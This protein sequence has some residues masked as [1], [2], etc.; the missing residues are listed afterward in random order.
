M[1]PSI[2]R[3]TP[4]DLDA[5]RF[6][7]VRTW[8]STYGPRLGPRYVM[9]GLDEHWSVQAIAAAL[10]AGRIDVAETAD[11]VVGMAEVG[12]LGEDLVLWKLYV[13]PSAQGSGL[14]HDLVAAAKDRARQGGRDLLTEYEPA[15]DVVRGFYLREGFEDMEAPWPGAVWLRW[16]RDG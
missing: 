11:G 1:T 3:A 6:I 13:T 10:A 14:G 8:P 7:G 12:D 4:D 15:N 5:V 16:R 2:R 9:R